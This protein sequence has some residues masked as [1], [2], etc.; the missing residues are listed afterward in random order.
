[1]TPDD[2]ESQRRVRAALN[3]GRSLVGAFLT[4]RVS[5]ADDD[6]VVM[7]ADRVR[8]AI[9]D[10]DWAGCTAAA[11]VLASHLDESSRP[12][13]PADG[14]GPDHHEL[15]T[16]EGRLSQGRLSLA[17]PVGTR[18]LGWSA[19]ALVT[20][21]RRGALVPWGTISAGFSV[22]A[23]PWPALQDQRL[24]DWLKSIRDEGSGEPAVPLPDGLVR[25]EPV[26]PFAGLSADAVHV[27]GIV[28]PDDR[29]VL[30]DRYRVFWQTLLSTARFDAVVDE[31]IAAGLVTDDVTTADMLA[32]GLDAR[33]LQAHARRHG[34]AASG[35]KAAVA[36]RLEEAGRLG[37]LLDQVG[38]EVL[39]HVRWHSPL[40][41]AVGKERRAEAW[42]WTCALRSHD[43]PD[44]VPPPSVNESPEA[45]P[46]LPGQRCTIPLGDRSPIVHIDE[47]GNRAMVVVAG[48][49]EL[50]A[51]DLDGRVVWQVDFTQPD[52]GRAPSHWWTLVHG[53]RC[54]AVR[55][56]TFVEV[57][58]LTGE[59]VDRFELPLELGV[60]WAVPT[61][62]GDGA[63]VVVTS[64]GLS[65]VNGQRR[66][67]WTVRRK[68]TGPAAG[69]VSRVVAV[70]KSA[71][72]L[73]V[74][75]LTGDIQRRIGLQVPDL[76]FQRVLVGD[77]L[78][79]A[80]TG[81]ESTYVM[82]PVGVHV[83][84]GRAADLPFHDPEDPRFLDLLAEVG[85][86]YERA[87]L[88]AA[89]QDQVLAGGYRTGLGHRRTGRT[90]AGETTFVTLYGE[91][92]GWEVL[93]DSA[94][95][96]VVPAGTFEALDSEYL[97]GFK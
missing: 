95:I 94:A 68:L 60:L 89:A 93:A 53:D 7:A 15:E 38:M 35:S 54:L 83:G 97:G 63:R 24:R 40:E 75:P 5:V 19:F 52:N 51:H 23:S 86:T 46:A 74:D 96:S 39:P 21:L 13:W 92:D 49:H 9:T 14:P 22:G 42:L 16:L 28:A 67:E 18:L 71:H 26:D 81:P 55:S 31:L 62:L 76:R 45:R 61:L 32:S 88:L 90:H 80:G 30:F 29:T 64:Q 70:A 44:P 91:G 12:S 8:S 37:G 72:L 25:C 34:V 87:A 50:R 36:N 17:D 10:R 85:S 79:T 77:L 48:G 66:V 20:G 11:A 84:D 69:D 82:A 6:P 41:R 4:A 47:L 33:T 57:D 65:R 78:V 2:P 43:R 3:R 56:R 27:L 1:M 73:H 59:C 58:L